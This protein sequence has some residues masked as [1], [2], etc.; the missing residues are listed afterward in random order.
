[1]NFAINFDI[2]LKENKQLGATFQ[3]SSLKK[4]KKLKRKKKLEK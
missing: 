3:M 4:I 1:M 2:K